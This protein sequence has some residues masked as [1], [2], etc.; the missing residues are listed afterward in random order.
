MQNLE[1]KYENVSSELLLEQFEKLITSYKEAPDSQKDLILK[2]IDSV[3]DAKLL[4]EAQKEKIP[5]LLSSHT[6]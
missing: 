3:L 4:F 1:N 2:K 6:A 5:E